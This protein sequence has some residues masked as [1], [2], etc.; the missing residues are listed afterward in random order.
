MPKTKPAATKEN[1]EF[2]KRLLD[3]LGDSGHQRRGAGTYLS[4]RYKVSAVTA[5]DWLNG[6]F[7][8]NIDLAR[9]IAIDHGSTFDALYF[10]DTPSNAKFSRYAVREPSPDAHI[11]EIP[12]SDA[13]GSC[14][15]GAI[16]WDAEQRAPLIKEAGWFDR[17]KVKPE[18]AM[19]VWADGDSMAEFIVDGDIVI[20]DTSKTR[21]RSGLIYLI[22]HPDGLKIKRLRRSINGGWVLESANPD[23]NRYPD[24][25]IAPDHEDLLRIHGEFI[26]RQGG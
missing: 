23:K 24:E 16:N 22:D 19:A 1:L 20:F 4:N 12:F 26:Y 15:G 11:G 9:Q 5:N 13:R 21:P 8:P 14:G 17:Y 25:V 7:R 18:N 6:R 3:L 10:G 2:A